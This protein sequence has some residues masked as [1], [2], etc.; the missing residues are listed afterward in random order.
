VPDDP[1]PPQTET[2][3]GDPTYDLVVL[4]QQALEDCWRYRRFAEDAR[5]VGDDEVA[6]LFE[7]LADNDRSVA[8]R[9]RA[10]LASR[11]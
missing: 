7:E 6:E 3:F 9:A 8:D 10:L 1:T 2:G 4:L 11:L 5:R